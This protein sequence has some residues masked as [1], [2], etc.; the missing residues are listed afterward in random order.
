M[1]TLLVNPNRMEL[2]KLKR[3]LSFA[4]RGHKLLKD[5]Q[6]SL[7]QEFMRVLKSLQG[8]Y[9][10][11][12]QALFTVYEK[13]YR[14]QASAD[15]YALEAALESPK[16]QL[17]LSVVL[18]RKMGYTAPEFGIPEIPPRRINSAVSTPL[19]LAAMDERMRDV[20]PKMI[21]LAQI[22]KQIEMLASDIEKTRRRVNALEYNMIPV[23]QEAIR[24][25][26]MKLEERDRAE[27]T[28]LMKVK[29]LLK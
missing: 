27:R 15:P 17:L 21:R 14:A 18:K 10:D 5:K 16:D 25:I 22:E 6:E 19:A 12:E 2:L 20:F 8:M 24:S 29:D 9:A 1:A 7:M 13:Y 11:V 3:R 28:V 26:T 4:V 23:L